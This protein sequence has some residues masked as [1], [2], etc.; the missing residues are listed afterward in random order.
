MAIER[1]ILDEWKS[2]AEKDGMLEDYNYHLGMIYPPLPYQKW[3]MLKES[4]DRIQELPAY[5]EGRSLPPGMEDRAN[6]LCKRLG[7]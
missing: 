1:C 7:Y 5:R 4:L 3:K 6:D 2:Q